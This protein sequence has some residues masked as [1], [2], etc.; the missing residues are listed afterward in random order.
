MV[1]KMARR[2]IHDKT[3]EVR[4]WLGNVCGKPARRTLEGMTM[5]NYH[6]NND[7]QSEEDDPTCVEQ[8]EAEL[9]ISTRV[10]EEQRRL[11]EEQAA[12]ARRLARYRLEQMRAAPCTRCGATHRNKDRNGVCLAC[13]F[14]PL[15]PQIRFPGPVSSRRTTQFAVLYGHSL[16]SKS[17]AK[18]PSKPMIEE[19]SG[20]RF[21]LDDG[22]NDE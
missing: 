8:V 19:V 9:A 12:E 2:V 21:F 15:S 10:R 22:P 4:N 5:C 13:P 20:K 1:A 17:K 18:A 6:F 3:C 11:E 16:E 14:Q 7:G